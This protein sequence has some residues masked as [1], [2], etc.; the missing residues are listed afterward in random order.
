MEG[1]GF[2]RFQTTPFIDDGQRILIVDY[3]IG[4]DSTW[5]Q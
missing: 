1:L 4:V 2:A 3:R 5:Q